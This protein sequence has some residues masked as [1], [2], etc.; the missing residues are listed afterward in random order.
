M[1]DRFLL[2]FGAALG[3]VATAVGLLIRL[4]VMLGAPLPP[5]TPALW[6]LLAFRDDVLAAA[7][8]V[9]IVTL[10]F[11]RAPRSGAA[12]LVAIFGAL[13]LIQFALSEAVLFLGHAVRRE[14]LQTGFHPL[15]FTGSA[16]GGVLITVLI[17]LG[18]YAG[19]VV[20]AYR[21]AQV[22]RPASS[23]ARI[24]VRI[25]ALAIVL[26]ITA[27]IFPSFETGRNALFS[28]PELLQGPTAVLGKEVVIPKPDIDV[29]SV[30]ELAGNVEPSSWLSDDYPL[31]RRAPVR[32]AEAISL[33]K[34]VKPNFVFI[35]MESMR[36]EEVG[37]FGNDPPGV[38]PNLDALARDGIRIDR[39]YSTGSFTP[40]GELGVLYGVLASPWELIIRSHPDAKL[41]GFP[42][43]L[44]DE[45]WRSLLWMHSSDHTMYLGGR[46]Y[47]RHGIPVIDGRDFLPDDP[48]TSWGFSDRVLMKHAFDAVDRLP[49]P[50]A[51]LVL[52]I[53]NHHPF[54]VPEDAGSPLPG[55]AGEAAQLGGVHTQAMLQTM[56][57]ADEAVGDFFAKAR[58]RPWFANTVFVICGD[59]GITVAPARRKMTRHVFFELRH[60]VAMIIYSPM[61]PHGVTI[62]GPASQ[63]DILPTLLGAS[64]ITHPLAAVG[65]DLFD[66]AQHDPLRPVISYEFSAR[67]VTVVRGNFV[68]HATVAKDSVSLTE[69]LL[70]DNERDPQGEN[71]LIM[72]NPVM[73]QACRRA[74]SIYL[75]TYGWLLANDRAGLPPNSLH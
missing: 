29:K 1:A 54:K 4:R 37:A 35:V 33:P 72:R 15:I 14:D 55:G 23:P 21:Y 58:T 32:S 11:W 2:R 22:S 5:P 41:T 48:R 71:N 25:A 59:H 40:E 60:R 6:L 46:F 39:A 56:H 75:R 50:F 45:G 68:Y 12:V 57:Y 13:A 47:R 9:V 67:T 65:R 36:A 42:E 24:L 17:V 16:A 10:I 49:E 74:A 19:G 28:I 73:A 38:T 63:A 26:A 18:A 66:P 8:I 3:V 34:G 53:S 64:G 31:A 30:R 44:K 27:W 61:L 7:A 62:P 43:I 20:L 70:V 69:E 51:A 52:T